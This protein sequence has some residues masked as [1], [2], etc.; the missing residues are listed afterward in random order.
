MSWNGLKRT[1]SILLLALALSLFLPSTVSADAQVDEELR[2]IFLRVLS[3]SGQLQTH[4]EKYLNSLETWDGNFLTLLQQSEKWGQTLELSLTKIDGI[5]RDMMSFAGRLTEL[6]TK[7]EQTLNSIQSSENS[8]N[9]ALDSLKLDRKKSIRN[10]VI[11]GGVCIV[12]GA[13]LG[14]LAYNAI[15]DALEKLE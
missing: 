2:S 10:M 3:I 13:I 7:S 9:E 4:N 15:K 5:S 14:I 12:G 6:E 1:G 11:V 8:V